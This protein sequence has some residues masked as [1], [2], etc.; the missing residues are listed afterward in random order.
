MEVR[1]VKIVL[2]VVTLNTDL[3]TALQILKERQRGAL[4]TKIDG[5]YRLLTAGSIVAGRRRPLPNVFYVTPENTL[6]LGAQSPQIDLEQVS[7][8]G[9][10]VNVDD[11]Q[12]AQKYVSSPRDYYCDGPRHHDDF[13]PPYVSE[14]DPCPHKDGHTIVSSK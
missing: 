5:E 14:G 9:A 3:T 4:I 2:P 6:A 7:D 8:S 13:P 10:I 1:N 11:V 12:M